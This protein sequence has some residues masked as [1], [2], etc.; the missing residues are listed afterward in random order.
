M[1]RLAGKIDTV[2]TSNHN[3][4]ERGVPG[5]DRFKQHTMRPQEAPKD[6]KTTNTHPLVRTHP[7]TGRKSLY[8]SWQTIGLDRIDEDE[9]APLLAFWRK[10]IQ[11]PE[12]TCRFRWQPGSL[13]LWDNR[14]VQHYAVDD[15]PGQRRVMRRITIKGDKPR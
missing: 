11:K 4:P 15:Y 8:V 1:K 12:L 13:A 14:C 5:P 7:E 10:H 2:S 6:L 9:A 3:R